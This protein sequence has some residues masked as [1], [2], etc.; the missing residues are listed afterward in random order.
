MKRAPGWI[1]AL[2]VAAAWAG[3]CTD[4]GTAPDGIVALAF[5][6]LP[7]PSVV[8][9]DTM[10]DSTGK[11]APLR[12]VAYNVDGNVIAEPAVRYIALDTGVDISSQGYL[13]ATTRTSG[14]V[15]VVATAAS[16]QSLQKT[17]TVTREPT[18][19]AASGPTSDTLKYASPD[20]STNVSNAMK[21]KLTRDSA[22]TAVGVP[23]FLVSWRATFR[24]QAIVATDTTLVSIWDD[25]RKIS[26]LDTTGT[27]GVAARTL[28]IRSNALPT[29]ADSFVVYATTKYRGQEVAGS[30]VRFVIHFRPK[31]AR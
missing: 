11:A 27:D 6:T 22:G 12:A 14:T 17:I 24:G 2:M 25:A 18:A 23:G 3:A 13:V 16:L 20:A 26:G 5:D 10:R 9:N 4:V 1:A 21:V 8:A 19:V 30:P 31:P 28:R 15:R 29:T 7:Y